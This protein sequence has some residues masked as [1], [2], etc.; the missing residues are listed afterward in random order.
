M[1]GDLGA[2]AGGNQSG[3]NMSGVGGGA[4]GGA[5]S[6]GT[7]S[8]GAPE[9]SGGAPQIR[10]YL[11]CDVERIIED[12]CRMCHS[13][14]TLGQEPLFDTFGQVSGD[15]QLIVDVLVDD[16][17]PYGLPPL[18]ADQKSVINNWVNAGSQPVLADEPPDC[19]EP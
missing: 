9:S 19:S 6:G 15:A 2:E 18:S 12:P 14:Q 10:A 3:G 7:A 5:A 16:Y 17:M 8:G 11:P 1:G 4:G 13:A